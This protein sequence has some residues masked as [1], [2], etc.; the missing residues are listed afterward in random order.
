[1]RVAYHDKPIPL[2]ALLLLQKFARGEDVL[3]P[4]LHTVRIS[5]KALHN[6]FLSSRLADIELGTWSLAADTLNFLE[7]QV[8]ILKPKVVLEFGSGISTACLARYMQ[9]LHGNSNRVYVFSIEQDAEFLQRTKQLLETLHLEKYCRVVYSPL[10]ARLIEGIRTTCYDLSEDFL[11]EVLEDNRPDFVVI[12]GPAAEPGARF[13]TL[14]LV[15]H[16]L[17]PGARF[18]LDDALRDGELR[19]AQLWSRLLYMQVDGV[20]LIGKGL[21]VGK[22]ARGI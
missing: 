1:M 14:P 20:H 21:L 16:F 7:Q 6:P 19:I 9:E 15:R 5:G 12:D 2:S 8:Q 18:F 17:S 13:G 10:R 11:R 4:E 3:F 22:V